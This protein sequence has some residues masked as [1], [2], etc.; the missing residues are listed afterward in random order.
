MD[1]KYFVVHSDNSTENCL[2]MKVLS[3]PGHGNSKCSIVGSWTCF[4]S[5]KRIHLSFK[6][7]LTNWRGAAVF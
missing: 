2:L 1:I 6:R 7:V 4:S 5:F 3:H